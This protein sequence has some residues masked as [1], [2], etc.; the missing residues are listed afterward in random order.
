MAALPWSERVRIVLRQVARPS[1]QPDRTTTCGDPLEIDNPDGLRSGSR[2]QQSTEVCVPDATATYTAALRLLWEAARRP[3]GA[4]ISRQA[5]AQ[6]P[7]LTV[8][9]QSWSDWRNGKNVPS[10]PRVAA[11]LITFLDGRV[12]T[13]S[14]YVHPPVWWWETTRRQALAERRAGSG[15][16]GRP[17]RLHPSVRYQAVGERHRIGTPPR[18]ADWFQQRA[19]V[20]DLDRAVADGGTAVLCQVLAGMGGVGKTQ[21]AARYAHHAWDSGAVEV[22]VWVTAASRE[23]IQTTYARAATDIT[24]ADLTDPETA[25]E[26]LLG[27]LASTDRSWLIVLDDLTEPADLAG[28][29]PPARPNGQ[30]VVTTRRR[31]AAL[32]GPGR[33]RVN[34]GPFT[35]AEAA[36]YLTAALAAHHRTDTADQINA[37]AHDLGHL[38]LAL[39][40]A[41]AYLVDLDLDCAAF[42]HRLADR[43]RALAE[44]TPDTA[45][46]PDDQQTALAAAWAL[47]IERANQLRPAGLARPLLEL[48]S[49]LDPN[50]IPDVVLTSPPVLTYV[51]GARADG[52]APTADDARDAL[53]ALY[54]LSL[55][56]HNP[57]AT[58]ATQAIRVHQLIQRA[59]RDTLVPDRRHAVA[60]SAADALLSVWP[61]IDRDRSLA[62]ALRA[63]TAILH[64]VTGDSLWFPNPHRVL[65]RAGKS[66]AYTGLVSAAIDHYQHLHILAHQHHGPDHPDT[67]STRGALARWR[68][69][70]GDPAGAV[71]AF[72]QLLTDVVRVLGPD[73]PETL[74]TRDKLAG[75]RGQAG[76]FAE[77]VTAFSRLLT[78]EMRALGPDHPATLTTRRN[79]AYWQ[80]RMGDPADAAAAFSELLDDYLRILGPDHPDTLGTR[81][82]LARWMGEAGDA[83]GAVTAYKELLTARVRVLGSEAPD[84]LHTRHNLASWQGESGDPVGARVAFTELYS[85]YCRI[86]G[87]DHPHTLTTRHNL[88]YWRGRAEDPA[89][90]VAAFEQLLTDEVRVLGPDHPS[91]MATRSNLAYWRGQAENVAVLATMATSTAVGS[92]QN[93][94]T[95]ETDNEKDPQGAERA[96]NRPTD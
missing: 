83:A 35:E 71:A 78:D 19:A 27:W 3:T 76:D 38:P 77:A 50:G 34:V 21:L 33:H 85:D 53:R 52:P 28:L 48:T 66:L 16:G 7:P 51:T 86:F 14:D 57:R 69:D 93:T 54:R 47:S 22:L 55:I 91:T 62:Q 96:E 67:L 59:V 20:A 25:T 31:D 60:R 92:T 9:E 68:G 87:P 70:A 63:N 13:T 26:V 37:L 79:L 74:A 2:N 8:K 88:A 58:T 43:T 72:E 90:A 15:R 12:P 46:L 73:H 10:D 36:A 49:L 61:D 32:T 95:S 81:H 11:F 40:Q 80:G 6:Q 24:G 82:D 30:V 18:V 44:L 41:V 75:W 23:A 56:D 89:S 45:G 64:A 42:R 29:W 94:V 17:T 4:T 1:G 65:F 84:T 39:S 5:A